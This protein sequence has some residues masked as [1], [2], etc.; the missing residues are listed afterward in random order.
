M[1]LH[2]PIETTRLVGTWARMKDHQAKVMKC[3][4]VIGCAYPNNPE[5]SHSWYSPCDCAL[6]ALRLTTNSRAGRMVR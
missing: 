6:N 5:A 4:M 3:A 2:R 1:V